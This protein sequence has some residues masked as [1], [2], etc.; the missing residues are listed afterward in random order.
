MSAHTKGQN[1]CPCQSVCVLLWI[2]FLS[3]DYSQTC[4]HIIAK[5][6][7]GGPCYS[8]ILTSVRGTCKKFLLGKNFD[9]GSIV[10]RV[11]Q[12][13][14]RACPPN[15]VP[16]PPPRHYLAAPTFLHGCEIKSGWRPGY[17]VMP[18][19]MK[20]NSPFE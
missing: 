8:F 11:R 19:R 17:E 7:G 5:E 20:L 9:K 4:C 3:G 12:I 1:I 6:K 2:A 10:E 13:Y 15:L 14:L 16:R 18:T